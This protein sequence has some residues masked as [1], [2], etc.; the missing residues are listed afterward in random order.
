METSADWIDY[1]SFEVN[2]YDQVRSRRLVASIELVSPANKDRPESRLDFLKKCA[3][4]LRVGVCVTIIDVVTVPRFDLFTELLLMLREQPPA[5]P[6]SEC[7]TTTSRLRTDGESERL[8]HWHQKLEIGRTLPTIPIWLSE[9]L[10]VPL[11][12][13]A[14]YEYTLRKL[15]IE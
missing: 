14:T 5:P 7:Y 13:E 15:R 6:D 4:L 10:A 8:E 12:L 11:D 3:D 9:T 1:D 2:V